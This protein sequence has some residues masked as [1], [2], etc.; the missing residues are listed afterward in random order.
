MPQRFT[1]LN[2]PLRVLWLVLCTV[3]LLGPQVVLQ[4]T[5]WSYMLVSYTQ[6]STLESAVVDTFSGQRPCGLCQMIEAV[7]QDNKSQNSNFR[8]AE[9]FRLL[10]PHIERVVPLDRPRETFEHAGSCRLP[11]S[12]PLATPAPPPKRLI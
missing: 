5:A 1:Q 9:D 3:L 12:A 10:I 11:P 8:A 6:E 2:F 4:V 7:E